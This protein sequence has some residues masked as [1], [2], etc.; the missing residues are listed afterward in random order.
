VIDL[1]IL[2][3]DP[4][5]VRENLRKRNMLDFPLD[6]LLSLDKQ[7]RELITANQQLKT[8]R[9]KISLEI[10]KRKRENSDAA[11]LIAEMKKTSDKI[12]ENDASIQFVE[13]AYNDIAITVPN[14]IES[15]VPIG[16]DDTYN[17]EIEKWGNPRQ[18]EEFKDHIDLIAAFDLIDV[19][20]A[21]KTSGSRFYFLKRDLVRLNSALLSCGLDF[22]RNKGFVLIQPPYMLKKEAIGGAII[23]SDFEDVIYK[24]EGE[25]LY[26]IGTSEHAMASMHM[27]EIFSADQLPIRYAGISPCFRKEAGAHGKDT[28]GIFR[29]HQFEKVEQFVFCEPGQSRKEHELLL[30]NALEFMRLLGIPHRAVILSSGDMGKVVA[31]TIDVENWLPSQGKYREAMSCSNCTDFQAR[32]LGIKYREKAHEESKF[33]HTLNSTLVA[34]TRTLIAIMETYFNLE[35]KTIEIPEA[36]RPYMMG[37]KEIVAQPK[38]AA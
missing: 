13:K 27:G 36:L 5:K 32:S 10:A 20:R 23:F 28:K 30:K 6:E 17:K 3:E 19:E 24:I 1:K 11:D 21:A 9:N 12:S 7:R 2:R 4:E 15:D 26:L 25:D 16:P 35:S 38:D 22:L 37:Q 8:E 14:F 33:V 18:G 29:V 34:N 31:K